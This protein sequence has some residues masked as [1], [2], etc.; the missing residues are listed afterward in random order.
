MNKNDM[1]KNELIISMYKQSYSI[2]DII[3]KC[4][5]HEKE[6]R[7]IL[8]QNNLDRKGNFFSSELYERIVLLYQNGYTQKAICD[9]LL[10]A[11]PCIR[12]TLKKYNIPLRTSSECNKRY[13]RNSNYFDIIDTPNK[14]YILGLLY[15]DGNNHIN[16]NSI[17]ISLQEQDL[18]ILQSIKKE[19]EYEGPIRLNP[20]HEKNKKYKN[21]WVLC[22][23]DEHMS[24]QLKQLGVV[25]NKSL[26]LTFPEF[27]P[28]NLLSHFIRGYFDGDG[29]IYYD[30]KRSKCQTQTVGTKDFCEKLSCILNSNNCKN[31]I[32][33]PKQCS[34]NTY[35]IQ[36]SGNKSSNIFLSWMYQNADLK[37]ERKY[38]QYLSFK[39]SYQ[40]KKSK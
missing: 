17:T 2:E 25:N 8:K 38:Q 22:I 1:Y 35:V 19:L 27:I 24:N 37:L 6:I 10:I 28:D 40:N 34:E 3:S 33:H 39:S 5:I 30:C 21:Q 14:A 11:E 20:L 18:H 15:A 31:N 26:I 4:G 23:N 16:H 12:K 36:T 32:K 13:K 7:Y 9:T 29:N